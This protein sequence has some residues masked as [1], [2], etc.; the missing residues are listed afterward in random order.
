MC[1]LGLSRGLGETV[2]MNRLQSIIKTGKTTYC[3]YPT[4]SRGEIT[5]MDMEDS[6]HP[7]RKEA[8]HV[9]Q[10]R[11]KDK[12]LRL[13]IDKK[14]PSLFIQPTFEVEGLLKDQAV[15]HGGRGKQR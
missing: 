2:G 15:F 11:K 13:F 14:M 10:K 12:I 7:C 5:P 3:E 1:A 6:R 9:R 8:S 4:N